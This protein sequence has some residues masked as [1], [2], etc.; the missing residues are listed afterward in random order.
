MANRIGQIIKNLDKETALKWYNYGMKCIMNHWNSIDHHRHNKYLYLIRMYLRGLLEFASA[1]K[2]NYE[3]YTKIC[4]QMKYFM[5]PPEISADGAVLQ[6]ISVYFEEIAKVFESLNDQQ[7]LPLVEPLLYNLSVKPKKEFEIEIVTQLNKMFSGEYAFLSGES[8][9]KLSKRLLE[10]AKSKETNDATRTKFYQYYKELAGYKETVKELEKS[11][12]GIKNA[13]TLRMMP[14][15]KKIRKLQKM[16]EKFEKA[17]ASGDAVPKT[18]QEVMQKE[19]KEQKAIKEQEAKKSSIIIKSQP[20]EHK[21]I[22]VQEKTEGKGP[23]KLKI[24]HYEPIVNEDVIMEFTENYEKPK[25]QKKEKPIKEKENSKK[26][27]F[28]LNANK[29]KSIFSF[30]KSYSK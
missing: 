21:I 4:E 11:F 3:I 19:E 5:N 23:K 2:E 1:Q 22:K 13:G 25:K 28:D 14:L 7:L 17:K 24:K 20:I 8:K 12:C 9:S 26:V 10:Y 18:L 30:I 29:T 16:K 6:L 27:K 15:S